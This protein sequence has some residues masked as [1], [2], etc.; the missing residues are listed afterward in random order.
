[1]AKKIKGRRAFLKS[2]GLA[3]LPFL[4]PTGLSSPAALAQYAAGKEESINFVTDGAMPSPKEYVQEL[5]AVVEKYPNVQDTYAKEGAVAQL[6]QKFAEITGKQKA[7]FMPSGTMANNLALRVLSQNK[8]KIFVQEVSHLFRDEAD[9]AQTVHSK[10]LIPLAPGKAEFSLEELKEAIAYHDKGEVF[11]SGIGAVSIENPVR[12]AD[13]QVVSI[14]EIRKIAA[15][16][17]ENGIKLHLDGARLHLASAYSGVPIKEYAAPFDTVYISLYKYLGSKGGAILA[18]DAAVIDQMPHLIKVY[19]G[20]IYQN[21]PYAAMALDKVATIESQLQKA[22][23]KA[24]QLFS[25]MNQAG[26]MKVS[27]IENG[28]NIFNLQIT[29]PVNFEKL[30]AYLKEK[31]QIQ[32]RMPDGQG[33]IKFYV[34]ETILKRSNES[35]LNALKKA[36]NSSVA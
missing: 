29:A 17:K 15:Y 1:M 26:N 18:G 28:S 9:A 30:T 31:E 23:T 19:G 25:I 24:D 8:S 7:I 2:S 21:W 3:T 22:R 11:K 12:R 27:K 14:E 34:N 33:T 36:I 35:I 6:E 5:Q 4:L 10:R 32:L 20:N 13:G 16:C